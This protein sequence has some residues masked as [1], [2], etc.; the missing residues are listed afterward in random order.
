MHRKGNTMGKHFRKAALTLGA[1]LVIGVF[2]QFSVDRRPLIEQEFE[3]KTDSP[4][5][6]KVNPDWPDSVYNRLSPEERLAQLFMVAAYPNNGKEDIRRVS[7]LIK[8]YKVGGIIF[9]QGNPEEVSRL[10]TYYQS[11]SETPLLIAID[12]EWG[13]AMRLSN[14]ITYPRQMALGAINDDDLIY[15]MGRDIAKQLTYMG[16][17][18]NFAPVIDIN[19]NPDN[20]VINSR[21]FGENRIQVAR[22]GILYMRGMQDG[23]VLAVAKH[24]PGHGDTNIDSH[25]A[26]PVIPHSNTRLD[27]IELFPF[28]VLIKSGV[29]GIMTA[30][31]RVP[32][33]DTIPLPV[34][35]SSRVV[36]SLLIRKMHF[37]GLIFT[38]AMNMH[39]VADVLDPIQANRK[40]LEAGNDILLMPQEDESTLELLL[41]SMTNSEFENRINLSCY[42]I[43]KAKQWAVIPEL[44]TPNLEGKNLIDSLNN[45]AFQ[46]IRQRLVEKSLTVVSNQHHLLPYQRL[47]TLHIASV[48]LG[49]DSG[50][51]FREYL[52]LYTRVD[53][54]CV[55]GINNDSAF[56]F[57]LDT[58]RNYNQII[59]SLHGK[60][61]WSGKN[62]GL[63]DQMLALADTILKK[64]PS[65]LVGFSN[66]YLLNRLHYLG[67]EQALI[68][69]YQNDSIQQSQT[70]QL[71]FGGI[72]ASGSLPVSMG[73]IY[74]QGTGLTVQSIHRFQ[75]T[76]PLDAGFDAA[77]LRKVDSLVADAIAQK[78]IP[79]CQVLAA[80][81]GKVFLNKSYGYFTYRNQHP[82]ENTDLYDLASLTKIVATVPVIMHLDQENLLSIRDPLSQH[83]PE[84][85]STNKLK[86]RIDDVLL[87]QAGLAAWIPFYQSYLQPIYPGQFFSSTR[88]SEQYPIQLTPNLYVNKHLKYQDSTFSRMREGI[89]QVEITNSLYMNPSLRDSMFSA[90]YASDLQKRGKYKYSDLGFILFAE[91]IRRIT[92]TPLDRIADSL[93]Y[94]KLG[95]T[96]LGFTPLK[97]F[98]MDQIAPTENDL[99]FRKQII[100]GYVHDPAA[101]MLGGVSGHAGLFSNANDLAKYMQML[102]NGGEYGDEH[103]FDPEII[104]EFTS[105]VECRNGNRRGLGFDKPEPDASKNGPSIPGISLESYGHS[106]FT[107]TLTW[108]DPSTGIVF[109]FLSNRVFPDAINNKLLQLNVRTN[110]QQAIYDALL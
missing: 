17:H 58:L 63:N 86:V 22:K 78:A 1:A 33:L 9:F 7:R 89:Y 52:N 50:A 2:F 92:H 82:V 57:L 93:F 4:P 30:H 99:I 18:V 66:P 19:N 3:L 36:D 74:P 31:L 13:P 40:A 41:D 20:P 83:L 76:S 27:S 75:Y 73:S 45:P 55:T 14:T 44:K 35:L 104:H 43:L 15:Q 46:L 110:I 5:F 54:F 48:A 84:L 100:Q 79:G 94:S 24:F 37:E 28:D 42:K 26:L 103:Y 29:S 10:A 61:Y 16:I 62:Y 6:L 56:Q 81:N 97:R 101:A 59:L 69:A 90:I 38:D 23:H 96:T 12:G 72:G 53:N 67:S 25:Q 105:C 39:G 32:A 77:K 108:V 71:I 106:G 98:G 47:D 88:Y 87:H 60:P 107:G 70:A 64:Y 68:M 91:M 102:L 11:I 34:S 65:V 21:S 109:I 95:A 51:V 85:D 8:K 80:R 49:C